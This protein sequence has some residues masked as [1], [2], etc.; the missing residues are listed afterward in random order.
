[1]ADLAEQGINRISRIAV[2]RDLKRLTLVA[3]PTR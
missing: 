1:V 3:E 2:S